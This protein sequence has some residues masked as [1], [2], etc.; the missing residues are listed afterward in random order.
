M[1]Q[2]NTPLASV[3]SGVRFTP[4]LTGFVLLSCAIHLPLLL[5]AQTPSQVGDGLTTT[6]QVR[7]DSNQR[8]S[9]RSI[10][11]TQEE[12]AK[13]SAV[14]PELAKDHTVV[15]RSSNDSTAVSANVPAQD[16]DQNSNQ[17]QTTATEQPKPLPMDKIGRHIEAL[18]EVIT[19]VNPAPATTRTEERKVLTQRLQQ[20][21][22]HHFNYPLTAR[23]KGWQG[24]VTLTFTLRA[25]GEIMDIRISK[26]SG[27]EMLDRAAIASLIKV[28][29]LDKPPHQTTSIELPV[30]YTLQNS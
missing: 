12:R 2:L 10:R 19:M 16:S 15:T 18:T 4:Q 30:I 20:A 22:S 24:E 9:G 11:D 17:I 13:P 28:N 23:R 26:S 27:H 7:L 8:D 1:S 6:M 14:A 29:P 3:P 25:D 21:L 5:S